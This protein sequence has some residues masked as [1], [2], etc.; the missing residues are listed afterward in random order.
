[1]LTDKEV[2]DTILHLRAKGYKIWSIHAVTGLTI[3]E[4]CE[5]L[6]EQNK[7]D[8]AADANRVYNGEL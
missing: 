7:K 8:V 5:V 3:T 1:M 2:K 6:Y 4:I